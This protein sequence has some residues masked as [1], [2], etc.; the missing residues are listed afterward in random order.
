MSVAQEIWQWQTDRLRGRADL[1]DGWKLVSGMQ[2]HRNATIKDKRAYLNLIRGLDRRYG[3]YAWGGWHEP[4]T[5]M[6]KPGVYAFFDRGR[7]LYIGSSTNLAS[8][9]SSH[10]VR[11]RYINALVRVRYTEP[12]DQLTAEYK[13]IRRL[14]PP[15]NK[16]YAR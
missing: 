5:V 3:I 1:M 15:L 14:K 6:N 9:L 2:W 11:A 7:L 16:T 8:R 13:L 12:G 4:S 10:S